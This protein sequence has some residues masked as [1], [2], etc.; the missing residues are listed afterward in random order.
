LK[1]KAYGWKQC[2]KRNEVYCATSSLFGKKLRY[3]TSAT[4]GQALLFSPDAFPFPVE[5]GAR[6]VFVG[7]IRKELIPE[8]LPGGVRGLTI[9]D[10]DLDA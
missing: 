4:M 1:E 3:L 6:V 2:R 7:G 9:A 8:R 5:T 10:L